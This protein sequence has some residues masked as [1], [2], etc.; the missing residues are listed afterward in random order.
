MC[1]I[2]KFSSISRFEHESQKKVSSLPS[3]GLDSGPRFSDLSFHSQPCVNG[4]YLFRRTC[5]YM[6]RLFVVIWSGEWQ[7]SDQDLW[8]VPGHV[9]GLFLAK[10]IAPTCSGLSGGILRSHSQSRCAALAYRA[11]GV[12]W[13]TL[14]IYIK[15]IGDKKTKYFLILL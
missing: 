4:I 10:W 2:R 7:L 8:R 13:L 9:N 5:S 12:A 3:L 15:K 1:E 14:Q 6:V 11:D